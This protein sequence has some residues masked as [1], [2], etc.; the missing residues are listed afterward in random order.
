MHVFVVGEVSGDC[1]DVVGGLVDVVARYEVLTVVG[2]E[3][4]VVGILVD[5]ELTAVKDDS[6]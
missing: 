6:N 1:E 3:P 2:G 4:E 5:L